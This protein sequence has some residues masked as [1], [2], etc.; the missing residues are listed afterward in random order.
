MVDMRNNQVIGVADT[1]GATL[2]SYQALRSTNKVS[3]DVGT[4]ALMRSLDGTVVRIAAEFRN[5]QTMYYVTLQTGEGVLG[6]I[7][8]GSSDLSEELVLTRPGDKVALSY[9]DSATRVVG[10]SKFR[11]LDIPDA[12]GPSPQGTVP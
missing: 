10:M 5:N 3:A 1:L 8:T 4:Q 12:R 7:F 9:T 11:N 6:T 2:R